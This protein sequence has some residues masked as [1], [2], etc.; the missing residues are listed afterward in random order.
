MQIADTQEIPAVS[1]D[2]IKLISAAL[3][4]ENPDLV[5][6]TGDQIK[7]YSSFF[8]GSKGAENIEKTIKALIAPLEKRGIPFTATFG[9]HDGQGALCNSEQFE[10]YKKS[11]M[12]VYS[13]PAS[14]GDD[15]TFCLSISDGEK[16]RFLIYIFDSHS[17]A[18]GGGYSAVYPEQIEWYRSVRDSFEAENGRCLPSLVFQHIPTP[19]YFDVLKPAGRFTKGAVRAYGNH[20]N[21]F[22]TL[23]PQNSGLRDFMGESPA[24]PYNNSGEIDAFLEKGDVLGVFAGHDHNNSFV[25]KYKGIDLGYTQGAGFNV[26]GPGLNRGVRIFDINETGEYSTKTATYAELCPGKTANP[27]KYALYTYAPSSVAGVTTALKEFAVAAAAITAVAGTV[28]LIASR[29]K[30]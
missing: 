25:A 18:E 29:K 23:D 4:A 28:K 14:D 6:F 30:K 22:Y 12:F 2:T 5:I 7:G 9:N 26:Y 27:A 17:N 19:E 8:R 13:E 10:I 15:G 1:P 11:P 24:A 16:D 21:E 20:K 3:D